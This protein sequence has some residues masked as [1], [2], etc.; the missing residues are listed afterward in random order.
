MANSASAFGSGYRRR[1][2]IE[3]A[4]DHV[5][6]E[7][8]D[9]Y[10]RMVVTLRHAGGVVTAVESE[11]KRSPWTG[12]PGAMQRLSETFT[13]VALTDVARRGEKTSNCTHLHDLALFAA[14]H[15]GDAGPVAYEVLAGDTADNTRDGRR[16]T[17]LWRD[18]ELLF[19]WELDG[20]TFSAPA[21]LE[22][23]TLFDLGSY[24]ASLDPVTAEAARIL[25]WATIVGHGRTI[26]IP[27][28]LSATA[29]ATGNCYNFQPE[30]AEG[31]TRRPGADV[32]FS[33]PGREPM[34]DRS[35][36]FAAF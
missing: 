36:A 17:R 13:G 12:C 22:G 26:D 9:D 15:A 8:E 29:Y 31:S 16:T 2:L 10:H 28:G 25:R 14:S 34:A 3:P 21:E 33:A 1:I 6:A 7:L 20:M 32:D 24:V 4:P 23:R 18:G 11:M 19:T 30:R 35:E 27:A 5:T